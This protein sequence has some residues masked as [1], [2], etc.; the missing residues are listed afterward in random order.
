MLVLVCSDET[1]A[2]G[3]GRCLIRNRVAVAHSLPFNLQVLYC[4]SA[5]VSECVYLFLFSFLFFFGKHKE[6]PI[7]FPLPHHAANAPQTLDEKFFRHPKKTKKPSLTFFSINPKQKQTKKKPDHWVFI[8]SINAL[9]L[10]FIEVIYIFSYF[11]NFSL[12]RI[13]YYVSFLRWHMQ[14]IFKPTIFENESRKKEYALF[15]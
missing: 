11:N 6:Y 5:V 15:Y 10:F 2:R 8:L 7:A 1:W 4:H 13:F 3:A 9:I 12:V 14:Y